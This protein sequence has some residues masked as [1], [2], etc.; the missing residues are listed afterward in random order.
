MIYL[1]SILLHKLNPCS[2][3]ATSEGVKGVKVENTS[4]LGNQ[5]YTF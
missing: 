4:I 5:P 2:V 3:L 1:S